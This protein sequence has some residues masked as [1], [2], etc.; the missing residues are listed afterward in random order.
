[1]Y[2]DGCMRQK[3]VCEWVEGGIFAVRL[4][5]DHGMQ[6]ALWLR[7]RSIRVPGH[8]GISLDEILLKLTS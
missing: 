8:Q 7:I 3:K 4:S 2:G 6:H 1:M 5:D